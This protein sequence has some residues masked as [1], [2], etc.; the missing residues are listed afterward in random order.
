MQISSDQALDALEQVQD[1]QRRLSTL[2]SYGFAAPHFLLWGC[3]WMVGF[4]AAYLWP[5]Q[6]GRIWLGL[7]VAGFAGS[8]LLARHTHAMGKRTSAR[9]TWRVLT[10]LVI[11]IGFMNATYQIFQP[12]EAAQFAVFPA[13]LAAAIYIGLGLW[14]GLRWVIAGLVL[15][16]L[17]LVGYF[18]LRP[19]M[20]LWMAAAGG[21]TLLIT[22]MWLRRP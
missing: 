5:G 16:T 11:C 15:A 20:M 10:L 18:L 7:D 1:A 21:G 22:G 12:H 6:A 17:A 14:R 8:A 9:N 13:L 3:I 2:R 4:V 19:Y